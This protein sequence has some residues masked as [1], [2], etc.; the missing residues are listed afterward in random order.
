MT[1]ETKAPSIWPDF[2]PY[3]E[4]YG[5]SATAA[6]TIV[7]AW[8]DLTHFNLTK[9]AEVATSY[10]WDANSQVEVLQRMISGFAVLP[11]EPSSQSTAN[12]DRKANS[13]TSP[14]AGAAARTANGRRELSSA[15]A[16]D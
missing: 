12:T 7:S 13:V 1:E 9:A 5:V 2:T 10:G 14:S 6:S 8:V 11:V 4:L 3:A 15:V 16:G